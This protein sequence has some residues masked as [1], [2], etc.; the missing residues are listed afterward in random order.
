MTEPLPCPF[1][2]G[3]ACVMANSRKGKYCAICQSCGAA[4]A[5]AEH[6]DEAWNKWNNRKQTVAERIIKGLK[7]YAEE[8]E[9]RGG[10]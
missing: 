4:A 8:L 10:R 6:P 2:G 5:V 3:A 9:S 1:C 7:H